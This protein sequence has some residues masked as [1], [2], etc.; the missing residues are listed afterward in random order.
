MFSYTDYYTGGDIDP[1]RFLVAFETDRRADK[2]FGSMKVC[3][4]QFL[5]KSIPTSPF[6]HLSQKWFISY[7]IPQDEPIEETTGHFPCVSCWGIQ[8]KE[9]RLCLSGI[10]GS[11][12]WPSSGFLTMH[13]R[14]WTCITGVW[15][16]VC[17]F[18]N[19]HSYLF[20]LSLV[21][22]V[23]ILD[24]TCAVCSCSL[25]L[26]ATDWGRVNG[27]SLLGAGSCVAFAFVL[28][29]QICNKDCLEASYVNHIHVSLN[30]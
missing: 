6:N 27:I 28:S 14:Q 15:I 23:S 26:G 13:S 22:G 30:G 12:A 10:H 7:F 16:R 2:V 21:R 19:I 3:T 20:W 24:S 11:G 18:I 9:I 17:G 1:T 25:V 8:I 29:F 5:R 4:W